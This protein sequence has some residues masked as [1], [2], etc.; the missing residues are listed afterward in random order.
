MRIVV[1]EMQAKNNR[2]TTNFDWPNVHKEGGIGKVIR[3]LKILGSFL[4][5]CVPR[6][7]PR[8]T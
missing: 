8:M 1:D 7:G 2:E 6:S 4:V 3:E 5:F